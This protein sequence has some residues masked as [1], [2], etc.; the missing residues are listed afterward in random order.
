[1]DRA[2]ALAA[3]RDARRAAE[4][5]SSAK[6]QFLAVMSHELRTP[7]TA[8]IGYADLLGTSAAGAMSEAT[9]SFIHRM[10]ISSW[11]L[12]D[13]IDQILNLSRIEAGREEIM[14]RPVA[15][16]DLVTTSAALVQTQAQ[17]RGLSLDVRLPDH[18]ITIRT[19][20]GKLRQILVN[21][22]SN[23]VKFTERGG[24]EVVV[25]QDPS[26]PLSFQVTDTGVG[27]APE[28]LERIWDPFTQVDQSSTRRVGGS[29]LGLSV[30][31]RLSRLLEGELALDS[32]PGR[33]S[34]F[35]LRFPRPHY[36]ADPDG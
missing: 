36:V 23:A 12:R 31:M 10:R 22:L 15:V 21:L 6:S 26:G 13:V 28:D 27:I 5:A 35:T 11:H 19:D 8:I 3:E 24:I 32:E 17:L 16:A 25:K 7:L 20:P 18:P 29:G 2:G 14:A 4:E 1:M 33:G 9:A 30:S 34:T